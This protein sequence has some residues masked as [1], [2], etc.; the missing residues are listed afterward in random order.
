MSFATTNLANIF[1]LTINGMKNSDWL[2]FVPNSLHAAIRRFKF[3][4]YWDGYGDRGAT[5]YAL[6]KFTVTL[7]C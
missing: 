7:N 4:A 6:P 1:K 5:T 3:K 2:G